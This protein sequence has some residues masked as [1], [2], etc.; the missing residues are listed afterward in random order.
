MYNRE[1]YHVGL[2]LDK[3][4]TNNKQC[5]SMDADIV[6]S[7]R[8]RDH[9]NVQLSSQVFHFILLIIVKNPF[10]DGNVPFSPLYIVNI[11]QLV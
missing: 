2:N 6:F 11:A 8:K 5:P 7:I 1:I 10:L 9:K 3:A 4:N